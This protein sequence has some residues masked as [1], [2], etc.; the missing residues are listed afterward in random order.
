MTMTRT[1]T[2]TTTMTAMTMTT[3]TAAA[4]TTAAR[5][6]HKREWKQQL[7]TNFFVGCQL[8]TALHLAAWI[9]QSGKFKQC[10]KQSDEYEFWTRNADECKLCQP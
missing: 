1:T 9:G 6:E 4:A 10:I 7:Y 2:V 8:A 3:M 5:K